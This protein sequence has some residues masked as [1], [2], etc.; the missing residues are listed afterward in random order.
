MKQTIAEE[1]LVRAIRRWDLVLLVL[2]AII[3]AGIFGLPARVYGV[4][5]TYSILA[6]FACVVVVVLILLCFAEASSRF[7]TTGGPYI[8]CTKRSALRW[9]SRW[10]GCCGSRGSPRS[11]R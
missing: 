11:L 7:R 1:R 5:G 8:Y 4:I 2:N 6:Y 10:G 3:G 9:G